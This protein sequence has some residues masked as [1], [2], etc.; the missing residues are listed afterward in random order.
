M[1]KIKI[2]E[3]TSADAVKALIGAFIFNKVSGKDAEAQKIKQSVSSHDKAIE[4]QL[5]AIDKAVE[6]NAKA[7]KAQL[8]KLPDDEEERIRAYAKQFKDIV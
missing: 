2:T 6:K 7:V 8:A 5:A 4:K 1:K 3:F